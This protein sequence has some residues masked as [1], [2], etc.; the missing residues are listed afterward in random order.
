[1][2]RLTEQDVVR[3]VRLTEGSVATGQSSWVPVFP[4]GEFL[5]PDYGRLVFNDVTLSQYITNYTKRV[6][7]IDPCVDI[8]HK[9]EQAAGWIVGM[10][11][12]PGVGLFAEVR[13]NSLGRQ[14]LGDKQYRYT[15][16]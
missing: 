1:M 5:H 3:F 10:E 13:W 2:R 12:R 7:H 9:N 14:L 16:A 4:E 15:S 6:R 8:D 11:H